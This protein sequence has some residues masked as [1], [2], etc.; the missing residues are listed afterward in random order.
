MSQKVEIVL[1]SIMNSFTMNTSALFLSCVTALLGL[2]SLPSW[3]DKDSKDDP[4]ERFDSNNNL[5]IDGKEVAALKKAY[6]DDKT[7][8]L[9]QFDSDRDGTFSEQEI[10]AIHLHKPT[11][12]P[13]KDPNAGKKLKKMNKKPDGKKK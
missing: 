1:L 4:I 13:K 8:T 9:K 3:A 12:E 5:R 2:S 6:Q 7:G 11:P 10:A